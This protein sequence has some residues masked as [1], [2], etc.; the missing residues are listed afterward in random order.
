MHLPKL[1]LTA[2]ASAALL[3]PTHHA[4]AQP[5]SDDTPEQRAVLITGASS[6][7]GRTTAELLA[8]EGFYVYA[9][10][11]KASDLAE[12]DAIDNI[13]AIR[14]DVTDAD[15]IAAAVETVRDG[16]RGLY[17]LINNAGVAVV[18][19]LIEARED[20]LD[21]QFDVNIYGPYRVT[22]AFAPMIIESKGRI[23]TTGSISGSLA[24]GLGG[25]YSM[26]KHAIEA[27]TDTLAAELA[28]FGVGVSV[29]D[30]G[31]YKS[32]I[33]TSLR[34]RLVENGYTTEGS[35]YKD[36]MDG[37]MSMP[38][39]RSQYKDPDEVAE[40]FLDALTSEHPKRRYM[41]VPNRGEAEMTIR[42]ILSRAAQMNDDH[43]HSFTRDELVGM[44]DDAIAANTREK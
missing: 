26:S 35:R 40:A 7:I 24:W 34:D 21:F 11:R 31:N 15:E 43:A 25:P 30:P 5:A 22:K 19:P 18:A 44:L 9:G 41:V 8:A 2:I 4:T 13:Q 33:M 3:S 42:S 36:R 17:A 38:M 20:D 16:G 28:P 32:R 29:I 27:F 14:L 23:T 10:A 12:L 6:G 39:D 37:F 1:F